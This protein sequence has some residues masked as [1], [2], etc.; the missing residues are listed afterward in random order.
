MD[1]IY[2]MPALHSAGAHGQGIHTAE[3]TH[4]KH[5]GSRTSLSVRPSTTDNSCSP[6]CKIKAALAGLTSDS[7]TSSLNRRDT[8]PLSLPEAMISRLPYR[9]L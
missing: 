1:G 7:P 6:S 2:K 4:L 9:T 5:R 8:P 3:Q